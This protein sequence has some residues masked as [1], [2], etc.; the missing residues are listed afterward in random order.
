MKLYHAPNTR[1]LKVL[2]LLEELGV[3]YELERCS[4]SIGGGFH[5]QP[6]PGG[7]FPAFEDGGVVMNESGAIIEYIL[8]RYDNNQ[9]A[10]SRAS[11]DWP[12]FLTWLH[13]AESTAFPVFQNVAFHT[14][15]LAEE[16]RA[17][18]VAKTETPWAH[19]ILNH[20]NSALKGNTYIL[21]RR[22]T[23]ADIQLGF[24][25]FMA[26]RLHLIDQHSNVA[27]WVSRLERRP[28]LQRAR[29]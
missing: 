7:K 22:F 2:W 23:A 1:S 17:P 14:V 13:Y 16:L 19:D 26:K 29:S 28:A 15:Q 21:G 18:I 25:V 4:L 24:A 27:S 9:L 5:S 6:I 8:D 12:M 20:I 3:D 11:S 10:P